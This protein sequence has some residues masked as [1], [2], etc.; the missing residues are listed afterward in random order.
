VAENRAAV[1]ALGYVLGSER[2]AGLTGVVADTVTTRDAVALRTHTTAHRRPDWTR[3]FSL[4]AAITALSAVAPSDAVGVLKEELDADPSGG[5]GFS[6]GDLL[7]DRSGTTFA[8][9]AT[10]DEAS[11]RALQQRVAAGFR[12][13]D[14]LPPGADLPEG[15]ADADLRGHW[16]GVNGARFRSQVAEIDRRIGGLAGYRG[17]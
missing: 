9:R 8:E 17:N 15:I 5:S 16:G 10:R 4:S 6:F 7:A 3:H 2:L 11:A 1:L 14:Y 12:V 13:D